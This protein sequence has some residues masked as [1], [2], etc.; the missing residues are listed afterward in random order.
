ML[1]L[2]EWNG[3]FKSILFISS[4]QK[5]LI[6]ILWYTSVSGGETSRVTRNKGGHGHSTKTNILYCT[7]DALPGLIPF[8]A[9]W[10]TVHRDCGVSTQL[11][12]IGG[13][14]NCHW[15]S[16]FTW[17]HTVL[18]KHQTLIKVV[19]CFFFKW[20]D[21]E[22]LRTDMNS[23]RPITTGFLPTYFTPVIPHFLKKQAEFS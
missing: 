6:F 11:C 18:G 22:N 12:C 4:T 2:W 13:L 1:G 15:A 3:T 20:S 9:L 5:R 21:K 14:C 23:V 7:Q 17:Q 10:L 8:L 16:R 19:F